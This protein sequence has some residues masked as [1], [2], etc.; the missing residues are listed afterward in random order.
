MAPSAE[1]VQIFYNEA[2][3]DC[4]TYLESTLLPAL[5]STGYEAVEVNDYLNVRAHREQLNA[6]ND[7]YNVP[8]SLRSH[9]AT[10]VLGDSALLLQGHVP[11]PLLEEALD[12]HEQGKMEMLL[13]YQDSMEKAVSY[14]VWTP[15]LDVA[16]YDV[17]TPISTYLA[18]TP[19]L[20][21]DR[22]D[23]WSFAALVVTSGL[24]DGLNPCAFAIL[25]FFISFLYVARSPRADVAKMGVLYAYAIYLVYFLIGLGLIHAIILSGDEHFLARVGAYLVIAL[26]VLTLGGL[27]LKPL[28]LVTMT[29]HFLWE[30]I[31]PH[32]MRSTLPSAFVGGLLVGLCTFPCS[33]GIYVTI[34]G[35]LSSRLT[36]LG[37]LGYLYLYNAMFILPLLAILAVAHNKALARRLT[38]WQGAHHS[39]TRALSA[40]LM[41]AVGVTILLFFV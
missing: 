8:F 34:L 27:Y 19:T 10:F 12:I 28:G 41:I 32:L 13:V 37:G 31:K 16:E 2:C 30:K 17:S 25:L 9:L 36:Y 40:L 23:D 11:R 33:G 1:G 6:L 18:E 21:S 22:G 7:M 35:L 29:P 5:R 20:P 4:A 14:R 39:L 24:L 38:V 15:P 3:G 26:G